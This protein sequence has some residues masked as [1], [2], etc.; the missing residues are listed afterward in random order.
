M[1]VSTVDT[2]LGPFTAITADDGVVLASGWT[3]DVRQLVE[4]I[5]PSLRDGDLLVCKDLGPVTDAIVAY[6]EGEVHAPDGVAVRQRL[7]GAFLAAAWQAL[8]AVAPGE[9]ITYT[10]LA[11]RTGNATASR[12]AASACARNAAA[13]FVPCHRIVRSDGSVGRFRWG[14]P[15]KRH[16]LAHEA[17]RC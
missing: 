13:L 9:P 11:E 16:L 17:S 7:G 4:L 8:R 10:Q 3:A 5:H 14:A 12:A 2:W 1:R 6:H 15:I